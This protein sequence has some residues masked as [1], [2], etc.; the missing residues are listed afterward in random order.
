MQ[1][2]PEN[3]IC[4]KLLV[5][6]LFDCCLADSNLLLKPNAALGAPH[7]YIF[8]TPNGQ[9][10]S[11]ARPNFITLYNRLKKMS[12]QKELKTAKNKHKSPFA[13]I[14]FSDIAF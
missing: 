13:G 7:F 11:P 2:P 9:A 8:S 12:I 14:F 3:A 10:H 6:F 4:F 1:I 5:Y